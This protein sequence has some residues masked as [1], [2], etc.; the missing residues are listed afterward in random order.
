MKTDWEKTHNQDEL[1]D[2]TYEP[3]AA[4]RS[5]Y[6][7]NRFKVINI[8]KHRLV[9]QILASLLI[10][11]LIFGLSRLENTIG[12]SVNSSV[13]YL[14]TKEINF[15]PV[16]SKVLQLA[17]Q[18]ANMEWPT[19][20][21]LPTQGSKAVISAAAG[22]LSLTIPVS[23][24]IT[25][26]Y[27]WMISPLDNLQHFHEGI[28]IDAPLGSEVKAALTGRVVRTGEDK[29]LGGYVLLEHN[30]NYT[31]YGGLGEITARPE[32]EVREGEIIGKVGL[33]EESRE[34]HL[35]FEYR[36]RGKP[37]DPLARLYPDQLPGK[38]M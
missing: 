23:G 4:Y 35:H 27:G 34:P 3:K 10:L 14:L 11:G 36:E 18:A 26:V 16:F 33:N 13:R 32:Q 5:S 7:H 19:V 38:G 28:D 2:F 17:G 12:K 37:V 6:R 20:L 8:K 25:M 22:K 29:I 9:L 30:Q 21:N 24:Q 1:Y 15:Q 31:Y